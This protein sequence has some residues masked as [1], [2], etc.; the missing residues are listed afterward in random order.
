MV[1]W[2]TLPRLSAIGEPII[3]CSIDENTTDPDLLSE[4]ARVVMGE[5]DPLPLGAERHHCTGS[6]LAQMEME[7]VLNRLMHRVCWSEWV[8]GPPP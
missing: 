1:G 4:I 2:D 3:Q 5:S 7:V 8:N 6:L